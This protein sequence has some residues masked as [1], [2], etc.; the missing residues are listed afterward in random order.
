M[1]N[2]GPTLK[3]R[4]DKLHTIIDSNYPAD[5][6][7]HQA[8]ANRVY[9]AQAYLKELESLIRIFELSM[10]ETTISIVPLNIF[11]KK[12]ETADYATIE[13]EGL[14]FRMA[15]ITN[16]PGTDFLLLYLAPISEI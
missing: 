8:H 9:N 16:Y 6:K 11:E 1:E 10:S 5:P 4:M 7:L 3:K 14:Y 15:H 13:D 2:I 12:V